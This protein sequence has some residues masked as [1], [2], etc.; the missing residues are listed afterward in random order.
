MQLEALLDPF[1]RTNGNGSRSAEDDWID[2]ESIFTNEWGSQAA[3]TFKPSDTDGKDNKIPK[4][5]QKK[6]KRMYELQNGKGEKT[7]KHTINQSHMRN[8]LETFMDVLEMPENQRRTVRHIVENLN[9]SDTVGPGTKYEKVLLTVCSLIA[10]E[11]LSSR[12]NASVDERLFL[13]DRYRELMDATGMSSRDH[14]WIRVSVRE[15][16]DY[17]D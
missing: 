4:K 6:L 1:D 5:R 16:S 10:D 9:I 11:A 3:T 2:N 14:S 13:T 8:D 17:F 7:R 15:N 12:K